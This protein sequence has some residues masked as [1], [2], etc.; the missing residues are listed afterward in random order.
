MILLNLQPLITVYNMASERSFYASKQ[1]E[2]QNSPLNTSQGSSDRRGSPQK[3]SLTNTEKNENKINQ[4]PFYYAHIQN[5]YNIH[6]LDVH[7][8][9]KVMYFVK[10]NIIDLR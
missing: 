7:V 2:R 5:Y 9:L 6:I 8:F 10:C 1:R 4:W 3:W